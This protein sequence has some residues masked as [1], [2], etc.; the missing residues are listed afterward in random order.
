MRLM[1]RLL[2]IEEALARVLAHARPLEPE[3]VPVAEAAGRVLAADV[4]ALIDLP[5]FP[6]S[7]MDG[8]AIRSADVP[9]ELP[10]VFR[11]AAGRPADR[12]L[13]AGEAM[14]I[15][16]GGTVP[17]PFRMRMRMVTASARGTSTR[18][19]LRPANSG[20]RRRPR[21]WGP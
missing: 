19:C 10:I 18:S 3:A 17:M 20:A 16:T 14:E 2:S 21:R 6:S 13:E 12:P 1:P 15:S 7:A 4:A 9:G 11:I 8:F 5:P